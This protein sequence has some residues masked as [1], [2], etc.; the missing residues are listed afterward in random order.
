MVSYN[1]VKFGGHRHS[2]SGDTVFLSARHFE[3]PWLE[4]IRHI[5]LITSMLVTRLKQQLEKNL[6]ITLT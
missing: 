1:P 2:G 5:T 3:R 4:S 6:K